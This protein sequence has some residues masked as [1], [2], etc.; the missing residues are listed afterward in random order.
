[1]DNFFQLCSLGMVA[2]TYLFYSF[3][4]VTFEFSVV[5][6]LVCMFFIKILKEEKKND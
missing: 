3:K 2:V 4:I 1:M 6:I 5:T